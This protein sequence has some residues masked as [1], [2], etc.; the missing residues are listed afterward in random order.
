MRYFCQIQYNGTRFNGWQRQP[1]ATSIQQIIEEKI[2]I[3]L[4]KNIEILGCGRTDTGVHAS[5][6]YFHF[7]T[8]VLDIDLF[9]H[10]L[11][12]LVG[13]DIFIKKTIALHDEAHARFDATMRSYT[14][15]ITLQKD[16]FYTE[17]KWFCYNKS[18]DKE[19][20]QAVASLLKSYTQFAPFCK[21]SSQNLTNRCTIYKSE[22]QFGENDMQ[23]HITA[24]RFLRGMVR[25]I[26]GACIN[27]GLHQLSIDDVKFAMENQVLLKKSYSVPPNGLF[28]TKINYPYLT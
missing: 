26:V 12:Q 21:A 22:W 20:M 2:A 13:N 3:L 4:K 28:L 16:P 1:N 8:E 25:L 5:D 10:K 24:D 14:Y 15:H 11:N 19:R 9:T 18:M 27:A 6:Y 17:T 7:D 23:Y